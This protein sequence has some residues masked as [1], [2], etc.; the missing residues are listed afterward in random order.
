MGWCCDDGW[1]FVFLWG[2]QEEEGICGGGVMGVFFFQGQGGVGC[3][4]VIGVHSF[5]FLFFSFFFFFN[6]V[7]IFLLFFFLFVVFLF[8]LSEERC[9]GK[10]WRSWWS[11]VY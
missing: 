8:F 1:F 5:F 7:D 10:E 6:F 4:L 2:M 3:G 9:V 11:P